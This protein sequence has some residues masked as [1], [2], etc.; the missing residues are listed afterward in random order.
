MGF[1]CLTI[2][3]GCSM[4]HLESCNAHLAWQYPPPPGINNKKGRGRGRC[5]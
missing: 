3:N 2:M 4:D 1:K 5:K